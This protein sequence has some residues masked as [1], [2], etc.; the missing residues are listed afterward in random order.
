MKIRALTKLRGA[1]IILDPGQVAEIPNEA[2]AQLLAAGAAEKVSAREFAV[3]PEHERAI[4][5]DGIRGQREKQ[6]AEAPAPDAWP[7]N[8]RIKKSPAEYLAAA[9]DGKWADLARQHVGE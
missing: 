1:E 8:Q 3:A 5:P 7:P 6:E 9:P 2:A 4:V